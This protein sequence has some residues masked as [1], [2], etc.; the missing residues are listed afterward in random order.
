M[1]KKLL[2]C[3]SIALI[4]ALAITGTMAYF[5][6]TESATNVMTIGNID[7]E[8]NEQ[9]RV[10]DAANQHKLEDFEQAMTLMPAAYEGTSI[11][12]ADPADWVVANDSAWK[13]VADNGDVHDKFVTVTNTGTNEAYVRVIVAYEGDAINGKDIHIVHNT[14][15]SSDPAV[16]GEFAATDFIENVTIDGQRYDLIVYTYANP[17][18]PGETTIPSLKQI[19]MDKTTTQKEA[20]KYG[21]TYDILVL[22][23][24]VQTASGFTGAVN[25]LDS[26]FGKVDA[27][28][29]RVWFTGATPVDVATDAELKEALSADEKNIVINLTA[30]VTYDVAAWAAN[31]M[32][33]ASTESIVINGNGYT[34]NFKQT[35]SDWNNV[36]TNNGA[37]LTIVNADITNSGHNDGPWNRHD[38]NFACDVVL[39]N[40]NSDKALAFK[41]GASL[42]NVTVSDANTS[43]TYAIWIQPNGQTVSLDGCTIDM[44]DCTD[45]R[46]IKIDEQYVSAP[47]K[48]TLNVKDTTFLTEEKGAILVKSAAGAVINLNNVDISEVAADP[49][50]PVWIDE[51][52][53]AYAS[54]VTVNGGTAIVEGTVTLTVVDSVEET[55]AALD[56]G[57]IN[58]AVKGATF[59]A[60]P[61]NGHYYV[62]RNIH[63]VDCTFTANMNYM[64]INN[65]TFTNC[66][67][68]CGSANSAVHYDESF[69]DL[70]FNDCTFVSGK[71]QIGANKEVTGT[72][73]FNRC[74]FAETA[75]T[76]IWSEAGIRVYSPAEFNNCEF[77][78]RVVLAGSNDLPITFNQCT[79]NGGDPVYYTDNTDGIIRGGNIPAVTIQ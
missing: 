56:A 31:G 28:N 79:M 17:V 42:T 9:Q 71:I 37:T 7:I 57:A 49:V 76:S 38:I 14:T 52:S 64:Y 48:V 35:D 2:M 40:V 73:T 50:Y 32:G 55:I 11:P 36:V 77:N 59:T 15:T 60:N 4:A 3:L 19:Y 20:A 16:S 6:D 63:F 5:T 69:G 12:W 78:N 13:V 54:L 65:A 8:L 67:F 66:I 25:A 44:I 1:K 43:D 33:G 61:F 10:D 30:D 22:S 27:A 68:D 21:T 51:A 72:V 74:E 45:G 53:A 41:A 47:A 58:V 24:A 62:D 75:S 46:G 26:A 39:T 18:Q 29:A 23:Q 34:L 70:V